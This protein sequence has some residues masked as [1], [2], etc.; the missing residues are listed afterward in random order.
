[1][2]GDNAAAAA[3]MALVVLALALLALLLTRSGGARAGLTAAGLA[4]PVSPGSPVGLGLGGMEAPR[5]QWE[6]ARWRRLLFGGQVERSTAT[7]SGALL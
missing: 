5:A 3:A 1:M 6:A 7:Q 2:A 4:S